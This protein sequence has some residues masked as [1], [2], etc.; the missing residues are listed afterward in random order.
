MTDFEII[1]Q[2][3]QEAVDTTPANHSDRAELLNNLEIEYRNRYQKT[4]AMTD[5]EVTIQRSQEAVDATSANH[6]DRAGRLNNLGAGYR[7]RYRK[8]G[9][10]ADLEITIQRYEEALDS[11]L[12]PI[13]DRLKPGRTLLILQA[14]AENWPQAYQAAF[15]TVSLIPSLTPRFLKNSDKQH[16]LTDIVNLA[17][18]MSAI[19]LNAAKTPFDAIQALELGRGVIAESLN[20]LRADISDLQQKHSQLAEE[21]ITLRDQFD[22][23]TISTQRDVDQRYNT[24]KELERMI[25]KIRQLLDFDRFFLAPS[26]EELKAAAECGPIV[27]I[28]VSR[29]RCDALI[30]EKT[31]IQA[32]PLPHL[33]ISDVKDRTKKSLAEPEILEWL[34][35]TIAQPVL[36]ALGFIQTPYNDCW[37]HIWWIPTGPL[38]KF[39]IH[40][41][42]CHFQNSSDDVLDRAISSY[43][44][45]VKTIIHGRRHRPQTTRTSRSEEIVLIAMQETSNPMYYSRQKKM[46]VHYQKMRL[47]VNQRQ[48][49]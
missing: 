32:L 17:S 5:L 23:L 3:F 26:E 29:Y 28:N 44:S 31:Q 11:S 8:T 47:L 19:A 2:R 4:D 20:E 16:L 33:H 34:W 7:D 49:F 37:P 13:N 1:I 38:T 43:S 24:N 40:A 14:E 27:I 36:N 10:I 25:E 22:A 42:G 46:T 30:I 6:P 41:A 9:A 18:D 15:K 12:S 39:P 48:N 21:Y 45:S 35:K